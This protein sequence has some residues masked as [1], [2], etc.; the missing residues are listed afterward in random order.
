MKKYFLGIVLIFNILGC[1]DDS[2]K[3]GEVASKETSMNL[4][5]NASR[6][7]LTGKAVKRGTLPVIVNR[8]TI[9]VQ[10]WTAFVGGVADASR[11]ESVFNFDIVADD[12]VD[13][14]E[15]FEIRNFSTGISNFIVSA[16]SKSVGLAS[17]RS[18]ISESSALSANDLFI[19][20]E[21]KPVAISYRAIIQT[22]NVVSGINTPLSFTL[23][24]TNGRVIS[25]FQLS[26]ELKNWNYTAKVKTLGMLETQFANIDKTHNAVT[27]L[28]GDFFS[29]T[30]KH[31]ILIF[32]DKVEKVAEYGVLVNA[33]NGE[34]TN[35][36]YTILSDQIPASNKLQTTI[37]VPDF[38]SPPPTQTGV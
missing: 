11:I 6:T 20:W 22:V 17:T 37:L 30:M 27:Y 4:N 28:D 21:A 25:V 24:P 29:R 9:N 7:S 10:P 33:L 1:S 8:V 34:S 16:K 32:N 38:K 35:T 14:S 5:L 18:V 23:L 36:I 12:T 31:T 26:D 15:G 2:I 13:A 3:Q 19:E